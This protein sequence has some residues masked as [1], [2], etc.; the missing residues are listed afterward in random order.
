MVAMI[1][2]QYIEKKKKISWQISAPC[3]PEQ[4]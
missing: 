1:Y 3:D 4:D 2:V